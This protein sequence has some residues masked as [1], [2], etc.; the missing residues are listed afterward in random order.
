MKTATEIMRGPLGSLVEA[1]LG[2]KVTDA[3]SDIDPRADVETIV[4]SLGPPLERFHPSDRRAL[5]AWSH[6]TRR[7]AQELRAEARSQR[8]A[9]PAPATLE[10]PKRTGG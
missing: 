2:A 8:A 7:R 4:C 1:S 10:R 6:Q 3:S 9:H 5:L